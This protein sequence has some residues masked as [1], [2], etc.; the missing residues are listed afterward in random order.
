LATALTIWLSQFAAVFASARAASPAAPLLIAVQAGLVIGML[1]LAWQYEFHLGPVL[2]VLPAGAAVFLWQ[3]L[4]PGQWGMQLLFGAI[5]VV[6]FAAFPLMLGKRAGKALSPCLAAVLASAS[7]FFLARPAMVQGG[8]QNVIG[9]L[10]VALAAVMALLLLRLLRMEPPE[11][12]DLGRLALVAGAVLA[13]L[14]VAIPLQLKN[15]WVTIGWALEG[16][17]LSW[18][19]HRIPHTGIL[20]SSALLLTAV[21]S[22][23]AMN[24]DILLYAPRADYP[25]FNWYLYAYAVSAAAMIYAA[26]RFTTTEDVLFHSG[27]RASRVFPGMG[28]ILLFLLLNIEIADY[29]STGPRITFH[30]SATLAQDLTYTLGWALFA[31]AL[32]AVGVALRGHTTRIAGILLM[33]A[34]ILKCFVHDLSRLGGLYRVMSFVGLALGLALVAVVLQKYVLANRSPQGR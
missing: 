12:R 10:P 25:I 19:Y 9:I 23:L 3:A 5:V 27:I 13:F 18:L 8:M 20:H 34:T 24:P 7:F 6:P 16:A 29:Y 11:E 31:I 17:A 30:F 2:S 4:H 21:F 28:A 33:V 15:Q 14:T 32:L 1:V 26:S 22:R